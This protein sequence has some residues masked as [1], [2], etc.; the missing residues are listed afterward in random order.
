MVSR[1]GPV[2]Q[3]GL[4]IL[5]PPPTQYRMLPPQSKCRPPVRKIENHQTK[6]VFGV[7]VVVLAEKV[8]HVRAHAFVL[9]R[10]FLKTHK[11]FS[12]IILPT[13]IRDGFCF[14]YNY[15]HNISGLTLSADCYCCW[16]F[17]S[18]LNTAGSCTENFLIKH[19]PLLKIDLFVAHNPLAFFVV[20]F[21]DALLL[22][23]LF[24]TEVKTK[25]FSVT[26]KD[27]FLFAQLNV[28][29]YGLL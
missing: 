23:W 15:L 13:S 17:R 21:K 20:V 4:C 8:I 1:Y 10:L 25:Q 22:I 28:F 12:F 27:V 2:K 14:H 29:L 11:T 9:V 19:L 26:N 6:I 5:P 18:M 3:E 16:Y 24:T 7:G